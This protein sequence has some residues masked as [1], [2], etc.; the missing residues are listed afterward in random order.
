MVKEDYEK[1]HDCYPTLNEF[2]THQ[3]ELGQDALNGY[4]DTAL[5]I[6]SMFD[7]H[8]NSGMKYA[9]LLQRAKNVLVKEFSKENHGLETE[10]VFKDST[11]V[12]KNPS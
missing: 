11:A 5:S 8:I 10:T 1:K 12:L 9:C 7:K 3:V 2:D 4:E 6:F